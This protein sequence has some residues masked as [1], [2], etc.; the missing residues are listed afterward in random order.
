MNTGID[1][2]NIRQ[3]Q[4]FELI[5][6]TNASFFLTGRA[7]TG[8]TTFLC[9]VQEKIDKNFIVLAPTGIAA[10]NAGGETIH[11]FFGFP[12]HV[13]YPGTI[14]EANR[15]K[16][17]MLKSVDTIIIDE[18]SMVRCDIIDAIDYNLRR[19]THSSLPFGGKQIVFVGDMFQLPPVVTKGEDRSILKE[20]YGDGMPYFFKAD[21]FKRMS[22]PTIEFEKVYRQEDEDFLS[23][24][25]NVRSGFCS[26]SDL[27]KLNSHVG[28]DCV[29]NDMAITLSSVNRE[30][31][32]INDSMLESIDKPLF[33][34]NARIDK[35]FELSKVPVEEKLLLKEGA[36]VMICRNDPAKRWANGTIGIVSRLEE[37]KIFVKL[38]DGHEYLIPMTTWE[39]CKYT[40]DL[41]TKRTEKQIIGCYMQ[42]PLKLA[43]AITI[44][45]SQGLTFDV[46]N[47]DLKQGVFMPG[48]LY[49]ALSRV[50]SLEGLRLSSQIKPSYVWQ[51]DEIRKFSSTFNDSAVITKE[52]EAGK[53]VYP[54][55]RNH[56]YDEASLKLMEIAKQKAGSGDYKTSVELIGRMLSIVIDDS[57]L[58]G[59]SEEMP[60]IEGATTTIQ[61]INSVF[62]LY[63]NRYKEAVQFANCILA[64]RDCCEAVYVKARA[65]ALLEQWEN[66]DL[67]NVQLVQSLNDEFDAK[68]Y[69]QIAVVNELHTNDPGLGIMQKVIKNCPHYYKAVIKL[70]EIMQ[71]KSLKLKDEEEDTI[72]GQF[73]SDL[74]SAE[75]ESILVKARKDEPRIYKDLLKIIGNQAF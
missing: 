62:C 61:F 8:K 67:L 52:L 42:F 47:V 72:T 48:Q 30:A 55:L 64:R 22:L 27:E 57:C 46:L 65:Y 20:L 12:L 49:V 15:E 25:N 2:N 11:S 68:S 69:Y 60:V 18:V 16:V 56:L 31:K 51:S 24:L 32:A 45:K 10:I 50:R 54:L 3:Q 75:F 53:E 14:A 26:E 39:N 70:R 59:S 36:Q 7:G 38:K 73:N 58:L 34:Y 40:Y 6:S 1:N 41:K 43:W 35:E 74:S 33:C 28:S 23:I 29:G 21:V 37:E 5:E 63:G 66:A 44:H 13:L 9:N 71:M 19:L 4:A 17:L